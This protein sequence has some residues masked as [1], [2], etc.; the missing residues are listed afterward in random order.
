MINR[1]SKKISSWL[2]AASAKDI[3]FDNSIQLQIDGGSNDHVLTCKED[4]LIYKRNTINIQQLSGTTTLARGYGLSLIRIP[5]TS[6]IIPL[7]PTYFMPSNPQNTL[8]QNTLKSYNNFLRVRTEALGWIHFSN[9]SGQS[10]PLHTLTI[11]NN[12]QK[13]DYIQVEISCSTYPNMSISPIINSSFSQQPLYWTLI[14][15]LCKHISDYRLSIM[16]KHKTMT[17]LPSSFS[18]SKHIHRCQWWIY[19]QSKAK[20]IPRGSTS[21]T[22]H[23]RPGNLLQMDFMFIN[24]KSIRG[25]ASM[26]II[27]DARTRK[28]WVFCTPNKTPP[29]DTV[30]FFLRC[31][32]IAQI[33]ISIIC[34]DEGGELA[35]CM[36]FCR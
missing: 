10:A 7:W 2:I 29:I 21:D 14:H 27:V 26:L 15:R 35:R 36:E 28:L 33:P 20:N 25:F 23:L 22:S 12:T 17:H 24:N 19:W 11:P 8:S 5:N 32:Q 16:C 4:F 6:M 1:D 18:S 3:Q 13:L 30:R 9:A 31:L 34:T